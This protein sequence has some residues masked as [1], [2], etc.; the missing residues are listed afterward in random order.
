MNLRIR[1]TG[2]GFTIIEMMM[3]LVILGFLMASVAVAFHASVINYHENENMYKAANM[4]RQALLRIT[5][6]LRNAQAVAASETANQCSMIT[7]DGADITY[8][9]DS[10]DNKLYLITNDVTT[11]ADHILC[12]NVTAMSFDRTQVTPGVIRNV[13]ILI[14]VTIG[15]TSQTIATAVVVRKNL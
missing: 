4:A 3:S 8:K 9:Y 7:T 10:S 12:E 15:D 11:D 14:T 2:S 13:Q 1:K 5:M 6:H